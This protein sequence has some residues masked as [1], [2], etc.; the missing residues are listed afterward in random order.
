MTARRAPSRPRS[1]SNPDASYTLVR[2]GEWQ[3]IAVTLFEIEAAL[4]AAM[5][6]VAPLVCQRVTPLASGPPARYGG[7]VLYHLAA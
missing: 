1:A 7:T 3:V 6:A 4:I 5:E 2:S